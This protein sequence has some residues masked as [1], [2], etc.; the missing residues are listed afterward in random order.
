[1]W[2]AVGW[3]GGALQHCICNRTASFAHKSTGLARDTEPLQGLNWMIPRII[4]GRRMMSELFNGIKASSCDSTAL[5]PFDL[6]IYPRGSHASS[7]CG[8]NM[9]EADAAMSTTWSQS[10]QEAV[11]I[12]MVRWRSLPFD[13]A[14]TWMPYRRVHPAPAITST[15]G[16]KRN[17]KDVSFPLINQL[18]NVSSRYSRPV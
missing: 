2:V 18:L 5:L 14:I 6:Q 16:A 3:P 10:M 15:P 1:M 13:G 17:D 4:A 8:W 9:R 12:Q 7:T 11:D